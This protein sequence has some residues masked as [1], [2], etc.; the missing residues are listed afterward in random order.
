MSTEIDEVLDL[1]RGA[2]AF[3]RERFQLSILHDH[4]IDP[5]AISYP[6]TMCSG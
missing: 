3:G 4:R 5:G 1:D 6:L 2:N